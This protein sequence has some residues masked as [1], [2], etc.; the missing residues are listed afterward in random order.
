MIKQLYTF[1]K[2]TTLPR[3]G[4][5]TLFT[6]IKLF[7]FGLRD[8][9]MAMRASSIAF[10]FFLAVFPTILF[11]F[12]IIPYIPIKDF[13]VLL[14]D[15]LQNFMPTYAYATIKSTVEDIVSRPQGGV[16]SIGFFMTLYF[17]TNGINSIIEA[18]NQTS[19]AIETRSWFKQRLISMLLLL[20]ISVLTIVSIALISLNTFMMNWLEDFGL[21]P[22]TFSYYLVVVGKYIILLGLVYFTYSFIYFLG[23]SKK[24]KFRFFSY[25]ST[26][27]TFLVALSTVGFNFYINNFSKY[28]ALYGSIGTLI[29]VLMWIY[30]FAFVTIIGF[31]INAS[32]MRS[33][34]QKVIDAYKE[35][36]TD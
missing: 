29:I 34:S 4:G 14:M 20:I 6:V 3:T 15:S 13:D 22:G 11:F 21:F 33:K 26:V 23:P 10:N 19:H 12:S 9:I 16:L 7:I 28:N 24:Q 30:I 32:I 35:H 18:F 36:L 27:A 31:E 2:E 5:V 1:V 17:A 8:G 25:G